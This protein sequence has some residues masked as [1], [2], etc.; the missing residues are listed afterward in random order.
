MKL[1]LKK[2]LVLIGINEFLAK[3]Y[4]PNYKIIKLKQHSK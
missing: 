1:A 2:C 3:I 4:T